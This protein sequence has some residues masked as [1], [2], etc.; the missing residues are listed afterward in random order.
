MGTATNLNTQALPN[1]PKIFPD[2]WSHEHPPLMK[3]IEKGEKQNGGLSYAPNRLYA[4]DG[5]SKNFA[6]TTLAAVI[7]S[8]N[9][10]SK[11]LNETYNWTSSI[12]PITLTYDE[13]LRAGESE[14]TKVT[15]IEAKKKQAKLDHLNL[16][17]TNLMTGDGTD[18]GNGVT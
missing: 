7:S 4:A 11:L 18:Q 2:H 17:A 16:L 6:G 14:F 1:I 15:M 10:T 12:T 8:A 3:F 9:Q 13:K 5:T